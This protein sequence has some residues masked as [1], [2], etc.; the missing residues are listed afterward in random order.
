M[1]K[2]HEHLLMLSTLFRVRLNLAEGCLHLVVEPN[3]IDKDEATIE[4]HGGTL[5][6]AYLEQ[7]V[8]AH[9]GWRATDTVEQMC[10]E[11]EILFRL[12]LR[13]AQQELVEK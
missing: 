11:I 10:L 6:L 4:G 1:P 8:Y 9:I 12:F 13:Y 7:L 3:A 5:Y 2:R